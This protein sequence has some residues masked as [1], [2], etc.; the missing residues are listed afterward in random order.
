M[1]RRSRPLEDLIT[2]AAKCPWWVNLLLALGSYLGLHAF[3]TSAAPPAS[4]TVEQLGA[5]AAQAIWQSLALFGQYLLPL[6]F[7]LAALIAF[8]QQKKRRQLWQRTTLSQDS[9]AAIRGMSWREFEQLIGEV[10]REQGYA[11]RETPAGADGGVDLVLHKGGEKCFVQCKH[12]KAQ[13]VSVNIV[14]ELHGVMLSGGAAGGYVVTSGTFTHEAQQYAHG[15][16]ITLID[17]ATLQQ[18]L[19]RVKSRQGDAGRQPEF[20]PTL[21]T[22]TPTCPRCGSAM[23]QRTARQGQYAG[24]RFWGCS[25]FPQCLGTLPVHKND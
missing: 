14:R 16:N 8:G 11:V 19:Q 5:H 21:Q 20:S 3:A 13:K 15:I 17:G 23:V 9:G 25:T 2:I 4:G 24:K 18:W 22:A 7:G 12:W 6:A 10:F 1:A